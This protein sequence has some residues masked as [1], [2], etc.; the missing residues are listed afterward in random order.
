MLTI[1]TFSEAFAADGAVGGLIVVADAKQYWPGSRG[2]VSAD[3][4][5]GLDIQVVELVDDVTI[6][7]RPDRS[8]RQNPITYV[9]AD[10]SAYT[11]LLNARIT[12][13]QQQIIYNQGGQIRDRIPT[14]L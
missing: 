2:S 5:S 9:G 8:D 12:I 14:I 3:G 7:V 10:L 1:P 6:R 13:P 4:L 11:V